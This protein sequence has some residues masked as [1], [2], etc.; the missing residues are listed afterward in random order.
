M[1]DQL[2][3]LLFR[4]PGVLMSIH[5]AGGVTRSARIIPEVLV[6]PVLGNYLPA[7]LPQFYA[8]FQPGV[9]RG[10]SVDRVLF[11]WLY[12][13]SCEAEILRPAR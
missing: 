7:S 11:N 1:R 4:A 5:E 2:Q 10:F 6:S 8:V 3:K 9:E 13:P 12:S